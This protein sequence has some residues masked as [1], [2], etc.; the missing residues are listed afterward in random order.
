VTVLHPAT[1]RLVED[2][3]AL[4]TVDPHDLPDALLVEDTAALLR[5]RRR[6]DGVLAARLL[7]IDT[8]DATTAE[9]G[10]STRGWLVEEQQLSETE[11]SA[12]MKVARA[13]VTR[14]AVTEALS[15]GEITHDHAKLI[16]GF[17]P[18]LPDPDARDHAEK[19]L[20]DA[21]RTTDPTRLGRGLRE[22]A[23]RLCLNE[24]AEERAV[25]MREG[26]YLSFTDTIDQ[27][28]LVTGALDR[29][30]ARILH[31]ALAPLSLKAGE[32][33]ERSTGQR[34]ADALVELARLAMNRGEL[35]D[36]AGEPTQVTV[37]IPLADLQRDLGLGEPAPGSIDGVPV[38]AN[39]ARM[40][41]C[42]AGIIPAVLGS[43]AEVLDLGR[44]TRTWSRAQRRAAKL[45]A[46]GHCE[47]PR[48]HARIDRCDLHHDQHWAHGGPTNL[49]N[50]I[51]LC[52]YHHWLVHHTPWTITRTPDG[53]IQFRKT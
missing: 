40:L 39:T 21:A 17:L 18:S 33:D 24:T 49:A 47:A 11:A 48:C 8:R 6:L 42:D 31:K 45:R 30:G 7:V 25:R 14:P 16:V 2:L 32:V 35:P 44:S 50:G 12:R 34:K 13:A 20:L 43:P 28:V 5:L 52:A 38:T 3:D 23:D 26:R 37:T 9:C 36:T 22:L 15:G 29:V 51:Y 27:M 1:Q 53:S 10:R 46:G 4:L 19:L 41:A